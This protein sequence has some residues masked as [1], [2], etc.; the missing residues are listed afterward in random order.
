MVPPKEED[1]DVELEN[2]EEDGDNLSVQDETDEPDWAEDDD[3]DAILVDLA[4]PS[5]EDQPLQTILKSETDVV[6]WKQE[7]ERITPLLKITLRQDAKVILLQT[8]QF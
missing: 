6:A 7:V 4:A 3:D 8:M 5:S 2:A 1:E